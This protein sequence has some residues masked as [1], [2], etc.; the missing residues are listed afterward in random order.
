MFSSLPERLRRSTG[1]RLTMWYALI[2]MLSSL[3][4]F[5]VG[6]FI[7]N[8]SIRNKD[9]QIVNE[10]INTYVNIVESS[11][12]QSLV[13]ELQLARSD[14]E[15]TGFF[16]CVV[17]SNGKLVSLTLPRR[18]RNVDPA[19]IMDKLPF[20]ENQ[21]VFLKGPK[22]KSVHAKHERTDTLEITSRRLPEGIMLEA[23]FSTEARDDF[24]EYYRNIFLAIIG[25]VI[26]FGIAGGSF[27]ARRAL[28]PVRDLT[29]A[30]QRV[31]SGRIDARVHVREAD[32]E[33]QSLARQFNDM[34]D[35]IEVL[36][37][38]MRDAL[39]NVAHDLR[40]PLARM[41]ASIE[42][43]IET[44]DGERALREALLDCAEESERIVNILNILMDISEAET[45]AMQLNLQGI[46]L[47]E[48]VEGIK[49]LYQL[50]A[51]E[52]ALALVVSVPEAM[53]VHADPGRLRQALANLVDNAVKY[54]PEG[55]RVVIEATGHAKTTNIAVKDTGP[56]IPASDIPRIFERLYR[57][58]KSRSQRGLGLGLSLVKAIVQAHQGTI[59]VESKP[60]EGAVFTISLPQ[61]S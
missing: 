37:E 54:T 45:G 17:D 11:G 41:R 8:N 7:L 40:T 33:L 43:V 20:V 44:G 3:I 56:G 10:K 61:Q 60:G 25:P 27:L 34:L 5:G 23:G 2:F 29:E 1:L 48:L 49:D 47:L 22:H 50:S 35:R 38:G 31:Q 32:S 58:D 6:Y 52:K 4:L 26:L 9:H 13:S 55:G 14:D 36:I 39:D 12:L 59:S 21:W 57:G 30:V 46:N 51:E 16:I 24:L 19:Y 15:H 18:W 53:V 28:Q 42:S